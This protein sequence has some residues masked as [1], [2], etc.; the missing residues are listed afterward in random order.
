MMLRAP[1]RDSSG[2]IAAMLF[3]FV[4]AHLRLAFAATPAGFQVG[5]VSS[6]TGGLSDWNDTVAGESRLQ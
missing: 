1:P 2:R 5:I 4:A 6:M 3:L